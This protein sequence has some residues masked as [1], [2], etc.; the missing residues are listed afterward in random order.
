MSNISRNSRENKNK[1]K[2]FTI[3]FCLNFLSTNLVC[4]SITNITSQTLIPPHS[5]HLSGNRCRVYMIC[6]TTKL[7]IQTHSGVCGVSSQTGWI[8]KSKLQSV[9]S[10]AI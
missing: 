7:P 6:L 5:S 10:L 9:E 8:M 2:F 4:H 1:C 3:K